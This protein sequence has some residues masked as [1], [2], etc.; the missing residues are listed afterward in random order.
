[1]SDLSVTN[2]TDN[3]Y[4]GVGHVFGGLRDATTGLPKGMF[5]FGNCPKVE[6][7]LNIERRKHKDSRGANRLTD[8]TQTVTKGGSIS[9]TLEDIKAKAVG[10]YLSANKVAS[11]SG[12]YATSAYDTCVDSG[13]IVGSIWRLRK[14]NVS[15]LVVKDSAGSPATLVLDTDYRIVDADHGLIEILSLGSYTQPFK[16]QYVYAATDVVPAFNADDNLEF[17]IYCALLNTEPTT[18]QKLGFSVYRVVFDPV[19]VMSLI[20]AEQGS[21]ELKGEIL[22]DPVLTADA[23]YGDFCR[24]EYIDANV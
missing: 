7:A 21:F 8:K 20:N 22:R 12:S 18:D 16:A 9:I 14:P 15:S 10:L 4:S 3:W 19:S 23:A 2:H 24:W 6:V 17:H 11:G 1:M 13:L 5:D